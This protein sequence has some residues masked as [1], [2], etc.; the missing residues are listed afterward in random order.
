M[1][2]PSR[3]IRPMQRIWARLARAPRPAVPPIR[4]LST[5]A[6]LGGVPGPALLPLPPEP[7][8]C[9]RLAIAPL[10]S[11]A[12]PALIAVAALVDVT[13]GGITAR[14]L[15]TDGSILDH[16]YCPPRDRPYDLALFAPPELAKMLRIGH[17]TP[18]STARVLA[19]HLVT[20]GPETPSPERL[21]PQ[22]EIDETMHW[23][24]DPYGD[25]AAEDAAGRLRN[26]VFGRLIAPVAVPWLHDLAIVL[27]PGD[28]QSRCLMKS[29]LYEPDCLRLTASLLAPG[30]TFVDVGANCGIYTLFAARAVGPSG[31]VIACEP[32]AREFARLERNVA[33]NRFTHVRLLRAA[34]CDSPGA[35]PLRIAEPAF[36][37]HN[38]MGNCFAYSRVGT[39][40][41]EEVPAIT[42]DTVLA[43]L[44][45]LALIKLDIE[46]AELRALRGA[47]A[48]LGRLRPSLL[49]EVYEDALLANGTTPAELVS[50]LGSHG[51]RLY[52]VDSATGDVWQKATF[53][54]GVNKN[55]LARPKERTPS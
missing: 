33:L 15:A 7:G 43:D 1:I 45:R 39:H 42:L 47:T 31:M 50:W 29:G 11:R 23:P 32:S 14:L 46:G 8:E 12:A 44:P 41:I 35:I 21:V 48:T 17:V 30:D 38:T 55:V 10:P 13:T 51:Y 19:A 25:P 22:R 28:E 54:P 5:L 20:F 40:A 36:A 49:L 27:E 3:R 9:A 2:V 34:A 16:L 37:G 24:L 52:D 53:P 26:L 18:A 4:A 6:A